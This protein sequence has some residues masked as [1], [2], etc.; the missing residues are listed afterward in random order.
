VDGCPIKPGRG[1]GP[2]AAKFSTFTRSCEASQW[3]F[4]PIPCRYILAS[5]LY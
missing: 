1:G 4:T 5:W 3:F 2:S